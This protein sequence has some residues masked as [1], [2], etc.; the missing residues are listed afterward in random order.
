MKT[1]RAPKYRNIKCEWQGE[2]FDSKAE[3][4]RF[5]ELWALLE[6]GEIIELQRQPKFILV[7]KIELDGRTKPAIRYVADFEYLT[8][9]GQ[10]IIEDVKGVITPIYRLKRHLLKAIHGLEITEIKK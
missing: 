3:L 6:A 5:L 10:R 8:K 7:K 1:A 9:S 2:K 4:K